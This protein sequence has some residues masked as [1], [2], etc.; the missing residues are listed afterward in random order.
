MGKRERTEKDVFFR[1]KF[2]SFPSHSIS[3]ADPLGSTAAWFDVQLSTDSD[4]QPP[5]ALRHVRTVLALYQCY[6]LR[7]QCIFL[8]F[9]LFV[10]GSSVCFF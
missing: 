1:K 2:P 10:S 4:E 8:R 6:P 3:P 5:T 7:E 9:R